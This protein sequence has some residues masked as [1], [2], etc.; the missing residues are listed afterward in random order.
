MVNNVLVILASFNGEKYIQDQ[1]FSILSQK[2]VSVELYIFDDCSN[3][4]T[5]DIINS[6]NDKRI[7]FFQNTISSGNAANNFLYSL[8][9]ILK[10]NIDNYDYIS[11]SDQDDIWLEYKLFNSIN[12]IYTKNFDLYCSNLMLRGEDNNNK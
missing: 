2:L 8:T 6:F 12:S 4:K 7:H 3:D 9:Y 10:S 1:I 5:V 11:F